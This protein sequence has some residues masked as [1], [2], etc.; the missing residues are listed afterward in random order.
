ME[1]FVVII[2]NVITP[3]FL[4]IGAGAYL[5][6]KFNFDLRTLSKIITYYLLPTICFVNVYES[7]IDGQI[8]LEVISYQ[9]VLVIIMMVICSLLVKVFRLDKGMSAMF[10]NSVVLLNSANY[11][12]PVSQLVFQQN[13]LGMTV[14][15]IVTLIQTF[16][17]FT[18]GLI[19]SVSVNNQGL[20][21]ISEF[22]KVPILYA[23]LLGVVLQS[24]NVNIPQ[25]LWQ[26]IQNVSDAFIGIALLILGAQV[27]YIKIRKIHRVIV[28]SCI[29]RLLVAPAIALGLIF[30]FG[31][32]GIVAQALFI[33]S[34][35]PSSRNSAQFALEFN[36]HPELAAQTV[37]ISTLL[38]SVTV[39]IVVFIAQL[40]F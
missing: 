14:Q 13:P 6:R 18:Y 38:S 11:G 24:L 40:L 26:P 17:T 9:L 23:L 37:L 2:L 1:L 15:I 16:V 33:A 4:L 21:V 5:H 19:N 30:L 8:L 25:F 28:L 39:A 32:E 27:A 35:Y 34:S 31:I 36:N 3:V 7:N 22:L 10:K 12:L 29:G 20:K